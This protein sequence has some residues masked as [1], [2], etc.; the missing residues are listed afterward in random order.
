MEDLSTGFGMIASRFFD[1]NTTDAERNNL[2]KLIPK[3]NLNTIV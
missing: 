2:F 1:E 3:V